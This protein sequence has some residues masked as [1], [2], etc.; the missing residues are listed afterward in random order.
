M[1]KNVPSE[2]FHL[3][4]MYIWSSG[5]GVKAHNEIPEIFEKGEPVLWRGGERGLFRASRD[6]SGGQVLLGAHGKKE[7]R[8]KVQLVQTR[9]IGG[10]LIYSGIGEGK[11]PKKKKRKKT[12]TWDGKKTTAKMILRRMREKKKKR[13]E[14]SFPT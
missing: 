11:G 5:K 14:S 13:G 9:R 2:W 1:I 8:G 4:E 6:S 7:D 10:S 3:K 12:K